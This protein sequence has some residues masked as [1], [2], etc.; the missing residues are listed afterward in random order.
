MNTPK[1]H[2][3]IAGR[4]EDFVTSVLIKQGWRI[5]ARNFRRVGAEIDIIAMKH[6]TIVFVE[7]K[8]RRFVP[9]TMQD[10]NQVITWKKRKALERGAKVFMQIKERELPVWE[11]LRFDLAIV[12]FPRGTPGK[13]RYIPGI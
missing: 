10:F 5:L 6:T 11:T 1:N 8:Y 7:V 9:E 4:A 13:L 3:A 2:L 12:G